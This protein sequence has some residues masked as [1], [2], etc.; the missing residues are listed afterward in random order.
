MEENKLDDGYQK[1]EALIF[2]DDAYFERYWQKG[3][4]HQISS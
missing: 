3:I 4:V 2:N 1:P